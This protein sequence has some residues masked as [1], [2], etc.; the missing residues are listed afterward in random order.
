MVTDLTGAMPSPL[1]VSGSPQG[2]TLKSVPL[3]DDV[4]LEPP[5]DALP[6]S[7]S[8]D[9]RL[10]RERAAAVEPAVAGF[11][12]KLSREVVT[13]RTANSST[14]QN[15]DGTFTTKIENTTLHYQVGDRW[16]LL[17]PRLVKRDGVWQTAASDRVVTFSTEGVVLSSPKGEIAFAPS[18]VSLPEP[19]VSSD[20]LTVTYFQVWPG[21][22]LRY[23][24][25]SDM[26]KEEIVIADRASI[27]VDGSFVFD[28]TGPGVSR[29][30]N[31]SVVVDGA[32]GS[33]V[34]FGAVEVLNAQGLPISDPSV[35]RAEVGERSVLGK[36]S[37][38]QLLVGVDPAWAAGLAPSAFPL[39]IDPTTYWGPWIQNA[40]DH[41][42]TG[43]PTNPG[44]ARARVGNLNWGGGASYWHTVSSFDYSAYLPTSAVASQLQSAS[45]QVAYMSGATSAEPIA[46][47]HATSYGYCGTNYGG[48]CGQGTTPY[49]PLQ[50]MT[51]GTLW[52]DVKSIVD[53]NWTAGA[54]LVAFA[55]SSNE[56]PGYFS[57]KELDTALIVTWDRL[58]LITASSMSPGNP[59]TFHSSSSGVSL[60]INP[61]SDPTVRRCTTG[62]C[63]ASRGARAS[64]T[65]RAGAPLAHRG[66]TRRRCIHR[67]LV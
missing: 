16:E 60:S 45:L 28:V 62:S 67:G 58:A 44:C 53:P 8:L 42:G 33:D 52:F 39:V 27:P 9:D 35:V 36:G 59:Y 2:E 48:D 61:L 25:S 41:L 14:F 20:G 6:S 10:Q 47:R 64:S 4:L 15:L 23:R 13:D 63:C 30:A 65:I 31:G 26:V 57:Y 34:R 46:V 24:V 40:T 18:G 7:E 19:S 37:V 22:D 11:D 55:L 17:D 38:D 12:E 49:L 66:L 21:V 54:P 3:P 1:G 29:A 56:N 32:L 50:W 43:C 51:T 5:T